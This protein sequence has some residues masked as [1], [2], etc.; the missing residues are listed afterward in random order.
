MFA[1]RTTQSLRLNDERLRRWRGLVYLCGVKDTNFGIAEHHC[2]LQPAL[3]LP[4]ACP[5][6]AGVASLMTTKK[7]KAKK[8][9][10]KKEKAKTEKEK[11]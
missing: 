6:A 2:S 11:G 10:A 1:L 5:A 7:E 9:K 8:E 4:A 3:L